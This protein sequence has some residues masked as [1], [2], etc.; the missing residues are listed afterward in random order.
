MMCRERE[1]LSEREAVYQVH[2][3]KEQ[4]YSQIIKA[5]TDRVS[6]SVIILVLVHMPLPA[7]SCQ[8]YCKKYGYFVPMSKCE[9]TQ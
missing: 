3:D 2:Y 7:I 5:L 4:K 6:S 8:N 1:L 9:L